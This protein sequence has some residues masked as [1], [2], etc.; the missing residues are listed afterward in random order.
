VGARRLPNWRLAAAAAL[1]QRALFLNRPLGRRKCLEA[2]VR[3]RLATLDGEPV[4]AGG[5]TLLRTVDCGEPI[6]K[7]FSESLVELVQIEVCGKIPW[8]EPAS[9]V[10]VVLMPATVEGLL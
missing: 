7:V 2:L 5:Q 4:P 1:A 6:A 3:D 10:T 8:L 9:V